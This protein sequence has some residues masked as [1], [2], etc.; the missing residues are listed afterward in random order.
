MAVAAAR[1]R[2]ARLGR[3]A[4]VRG[5]ADERRLDAVQRGRG[6]HDDA[7]DRAGV[8]VDEAE[9]GAERRRVEG[10]RAAQADLLAGREHQLDAGVRAP[11]ATTRRMA[12]SMHR[13]GRLVVA[14]EDGRVAVGQLAV[15]QLDLDRPGH[16]HGVE[17]G[18][19]T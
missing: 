5:A 11:S 4:G 3:D 10:G 17:V 2:C 14:A 8:V 15:D 13:D 6:A 16:R 1:S 19:R 12:S 7:A 9:A 18:A